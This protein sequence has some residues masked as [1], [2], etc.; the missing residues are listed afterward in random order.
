M[1]TVCG[2]SAGCE[3]WYKQSCP[4]KTPVQRAWYWRGS[5]HDLPSHFDSWHNAGI[6]EDLFPWRS[7]EHRCLADYTM[8]LFFTVPTWCGYLVVLGESLLIFH[9]FVV[10]HETAHLEK[11]NACLEWWTVII[12]REQLLSQGFTEDADEGS[13][14]LE[15]QFDMLHT[16]HFRIVSSVFF[17]FFFQFIDGLPSGLQL[18]CAGRGASC[19]DETPAVEDICKVCPGCCR[20]CDGYRENRLKW[21]EMTSIPLLERL[22]RIRQKGCFEVSVGIYMLYSL[23]I[24]AIFDSTDAL[25]NSERFLY[26]F[27]YCL[28]SFGPIESDRWIPLG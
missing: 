8:L 9:F 15:N 14:C 16:F 4:Y 25:Q 21:I 6:A 10:M 22:H 7:T 20:Q 13:T 23:S 17:Q 28:Q 11:G 27:V 26:A 1:D 3:T 2:L 5:L 12:E 24:L 18:P 19:P